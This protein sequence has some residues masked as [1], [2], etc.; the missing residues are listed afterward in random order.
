MTQRSKSWAIGLKSMELFHQLHA[1][2]ILCCNPAALLRA[3][4]LRVYQV[5]Q[6]PLSLPGV[7]DLMNSKSGSTLNLHSCQKRGISHSIIQRPAG[8]WP[9]KRTMKYL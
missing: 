5:L 7:Q 6:V 2:H 1:E 8:H 3:I 4:T 9:K